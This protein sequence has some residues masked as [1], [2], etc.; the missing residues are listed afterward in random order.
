MLLETYSLVS[1]YWHNVWFT[2]QFIL[3]R[4]AHLDQKEIVWPE[5]KTSNCSLFNFSML[6]KGNFI[7][8]SWYNKNK[9]THRLWSYCFISVNEKRT[10]ICYYSPTNLETPGLFH[11]LNKVK[12]CSSHGYLVTSYWALSAPLTLFTIFKSILQISARFSHTIG[13]EKCAKSPTSYL[14]TH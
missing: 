6:F 7:Y 8:K 13:T 2:W 12:Y 9:L 3:A 1:D 10:D 4:T 5:C 11:R 14:T